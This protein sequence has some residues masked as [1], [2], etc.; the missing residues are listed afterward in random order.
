MNIRLLVLIILNQTRVGKHMKKHTIEKWRYEMEYKLF[1]YYFCL[2]VKYMG[3]GGAQFSK[4][5][6]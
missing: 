2:M 1:I 4:L 5:Y 6:I 3:H